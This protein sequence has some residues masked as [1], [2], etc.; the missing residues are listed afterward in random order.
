[1]LSN[2]RGQGPRALNCFGTSIPFD[3]QIRHNK[4]SGEACFTV[5]HAPVTEGAG[6]HRPSFGTPIYAHV[7]AYHRGI[8]F[9]KVT[10]LGEGN[11]YGVHHAAR[12]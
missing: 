4:P 1:M 3:N 9:C 11:F 8:K 10:K 12:P 6:H 2:P 5:K 7:V